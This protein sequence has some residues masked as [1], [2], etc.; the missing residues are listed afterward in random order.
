VRRAGSL[1]AALAA[2]MLASA[3]LAAAPAAEQWRRI[4]FD[5]DLTS[6][7]V[8]LQSV[9]KQGDTA[10]VW[11]L[12]VPG[13]TSLSTGSENHTL[14]QRRFDCRGGSQKLGDVLL[15]RKLSAKAEKLPH[16]DLSFRVQPGSMDEIEMKLACEGQAPPT[17]AATI[18]YSS[19]KEA[20]AKAFGDAIKLPREQ[21]NRTLRGMGPGGPMPQSGNARQGGAPPPGGPP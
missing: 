19:V 5:A 18:E 6:Y 16:E 11:E 9:Q 13:R 2:P 3:A 20:V 1:A 10:T 15:Y 17:T 8:N 12:N 4:D 21:S 7:L 14:V